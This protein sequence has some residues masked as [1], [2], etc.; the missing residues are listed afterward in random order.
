MFTIAIILKEIINQ[1]HNDL[2]ADHFDIDKT[3]KFII[4]KN[5]WPKL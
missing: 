4:W 1:Y 3:K 5:Y 2:L